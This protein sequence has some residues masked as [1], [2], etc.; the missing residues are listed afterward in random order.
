[1]LV[2]PGP[3]LPARAEGEPVGSPDGKAIAVVTAE[4]PSSFWPGG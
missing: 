1:M 2:H 4:Q 3:G